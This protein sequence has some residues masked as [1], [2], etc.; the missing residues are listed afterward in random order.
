MSD[1]SSEEC[2]DQSPVYIQHK[3]PSESHATLERVRR[4]K[5]EYNLSWKELLTFAA[6]CCE[7]GDDDVIDERVGAAL[8]A[9]D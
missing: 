3:W 5:D 7:E 8:R 2:D 1:S 9:I 4:V 6:I